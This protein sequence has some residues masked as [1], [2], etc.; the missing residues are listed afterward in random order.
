MAI[1]GSENT[2]TYCRI[3][4]SL[5]LSHIHINTHV[6]TH[7][8]AH[9]RMHAHTH[10]VSTQTHPHLYLSLNREGCWGKT[11]NFTASFLHFS[12]FST[13]LWDLAN[14]RPVHSLKLSSHL[15]LSLPGLLPPFILPCKVVLARPGERL[16]CPY[17]C[18][19]SRGP[20]ACWILAQTHT[21]TLYK[22]LNTRGNMT[23]SAVWHPANWHEE[24]SA[25]W[26]SA[27][28]TTGCSSVIIKIKIK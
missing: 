15:F 3:S 24:K 1:C 22:S 20:I 25:D 27:S 12:L 2:T 8:H 10:T 23:Q 19:S 17:H 16:T 26:N 13:A 9:A 21:R 28:Q 7:T 14:S 11:D 18:R 6:H 5:S 4:L